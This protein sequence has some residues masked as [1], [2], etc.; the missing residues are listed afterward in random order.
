MKR[1]IALTSLAAATAA[2]MV[3]LPVL[4]KPELPAVQVFK[5]PSCGCC[6][7]WVDHMKA[8][9]FV[10]TVTEV[11]GTSVARKRYGMPERFG[12]CHTAVVA[13]YVVE[14]HVPADDVKRLLAIKPLAVGLAVPGMPD[15]SPG[16]E[17]GSRKDPYKVL[18]VDG[19]GNESVFSTYP[20]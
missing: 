13:G 9:G 3:G 11:D 1:R 5:N 12:S 17:M 16:M 8:A 2:A 4:A 20:K 6:G 19:S 15:G 18:L 10:V 14:G 7:A